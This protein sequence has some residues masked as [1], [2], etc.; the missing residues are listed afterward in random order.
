MLT[1]CSLNRTKRLTTGL[2]SHR[3]ARSQLS[4][5]V[6]SLVPY[7]RRFVC[8]LRTLLPSTMRTHTDVAQPNLPF[9]PHLG[10][11]F[12]R[13]CTSRSQ[14]RTTTTTTAHTIT[15]PVAASH[16]LSHSL[17]INPQYCQW[18]CQQVGD[19]NAC[20]TAPDKDEGASMTH[21]RL[22]SG[23][24]T[25]ELDAPSHRLYTSRLIGDGLA[26]HLMLPPAV[27]YP[28]K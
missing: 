14:G 25:R 11:R 26:S 17:C 24:L 21:T 16:Q 8:Y 6:G 18:H 5:L 23:R 1:K 10:H 22:R 7:L 4:Q 12:A 15:Q 13:A 19:D 20:A 28:P 2:L 27:A 9:V 3:S